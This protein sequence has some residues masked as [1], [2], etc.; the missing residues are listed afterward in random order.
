M[1][2]LIRPTETAQRPVAQGF[3]DHFFSLQIRLLASWRCTTVDGSCACATIS[4]QTSQSILMTCSPKR[5]RLTIAKACL[6]DVVFPVCGLIVC[7]VMPHGR[8]AYVRTSSMPPA[9]T[10]PRPDPLINS[11]TFSSTEA[12]H[13]LGFAHR[14]QTR[15][16]SI[17]VS[18]C[19]KGKRAQGISASV[20]ESHIKRNFFLKSATGTWRRKCFLLRSFF[21]KK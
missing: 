10:Q 8:C 17:T 16:L 15:P 19:F 2:T 12:W 4:L 1:L 6:S 21:L 14:D 9:V 13:K 3:F 18:G 11:G 7:H 20:I 5:S